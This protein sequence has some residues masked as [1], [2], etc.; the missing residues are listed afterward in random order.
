[1]EIIEIEAI[2]LSH[3]L[4]EGRGVGSARGI[5]TTRSTT[6]VKLKTADGSVGWGEAFAPARTTATLIEELFADKIVGMDPFA[7][8]SLA[9]ES[10]ME[11]YHFG[12]SAIVQ[13]AL[14]GID[15]AMWD[16]IGKIVNR[17]VHQILGGKKT[18]SLTPYASTMYVTEWDQDPAEPIERAI[19]EG[20]TAAKIKIGRGFEDDIERV[21]T[22]REIL[23]DNASLMVDFNG[24]YRPKQVARSVENLSEFD[25]AWIEEPVP[26]ENHSGYRQVRDLV[27]IPIATGEAHYNRFEFKQLI[28]DRTVDIV[29]P[30]L[31]RCGGF[32]EARRIAD[33]ATTENVAIRP[34][35]WNSSVGLAAAIQFAASVPKYPHADYIPEPLLFEFDR[36]KNPLRDDLMIDSI[37]PTG[38][39][40]E[41]PQDPG[42]GI[43]V[44]EDA[45]ERYR[46]D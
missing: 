13:C 45:V 3:S 22:A 16:L 24:N 38:G 44:D 43:S 46:I 34:H 4:D 7:V 32:S 9:E 31:G 23:G 21:R 41:V 19:E 18:T 10:Y 12:G 1:M 15:V 5:H 20:F 6:L 36:S 14:S 26:P 27:D 29:Q 28:D 17:P 30:N 33:M 2:P 35:V 39:V 8:E 40:L 37:D 25:I 42:L 11:G